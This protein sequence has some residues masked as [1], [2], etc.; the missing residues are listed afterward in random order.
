MNHKLRLFLTAF[1]LFFTTMLH[2]DEG[3]WLLSTLKQLNEADMQKMGFKLTADDIYNINKSSMKDGII[4]FGGGCT[5]EIVSPDGL[6]LTNHHCGLDY[7]QSLSSLDHDYLTNGF[8]ATARDK[9]L[10]APGLSVKF[11]IRMEDVTQKVKAEISDTLSEADL[12]AKLPGI[13][14]KLTK[15]ATAGNEFYTADVR[16]MYGGNEYFLFVYE[17]YEDVRLVGT[18]P[19]SIGNFGGDTDN[20]MWP[21]QTGDFSMFRIYTTPDGKPAKY[22]KENVPL[23]SKYYFP[24]SIKGVKEGDFAMI[25]GYPGR[26]DRYATSYSIE[27]GLDIT[28]PSLVK[29]RTKRLDVINNAMADNDAIRIKY[30]AKR[31]QV[32]NYWKYFIGQQKQLKRMKVVEQKRNLENQ[33]TTW[34]NADKK[35]RLH[36]G[37]VMGNLQQSYDNARKYAKLRVYTSEALMG[38]EILRYAFSFSALDKALNEKEPNA[39]DIKAKAAMLKSRVEDY[40]EEYDAGVDQKVFAVLVKSFADDVAKD[41]QSPIFAEMAKKY[42]GDYNKMAAAVFAKS[43]FSDKNKVLAFLEN[44]L[45]KKLK[46]DPAFKLINT[47]LS[48]YDDNFR[49]PIRTI[50]LALAANNRLYIEGLREM[51]PDKKLYPDANSTMRLSYG[52]VRAYDPA[53]AVKYSYF[54]TIEGVMQKMD[55]S[56]TEFKVPEKL[57]ELYNKKDY[58]RYGSNGT[59]NTCFLT[60]NDITGGNSGSPVINGNGEIIGLAFDGNWEAMSGDIKYDE[61]YKRTICVDIRY[62]LFCID[63]FG[64]AKHIVDE[65]K[66][67]E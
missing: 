19:M 30:Q 31:N 41:Q 22:A 16:A 28:S 42:K 10:P 21:R 51:M 3:M 18:P 8:W 5:G 63:K 67:V 62:V 45:A 64:G 6:I 43:I 57:V 15:E 55:N 38:T 12:Q 53:D 7:I 24:V 11:L 26:T 40:F 46:N 13:Y 65:M 39:D 35:R 56:N 49:A 17:R 9:E 23:K 50:D 4:H 34:V 2:A 59:L 25:M 36:Y 52:S 20:W 54:T 60:N 47:Q 48:F 33:F 58:G 27:N 37:F 14:S 32:S 44:P 66:V 61:E 1:A 29:L